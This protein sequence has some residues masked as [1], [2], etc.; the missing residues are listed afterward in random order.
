MC[1]Y[2]NKH[3][4]VLIVMCGFSAASIGICINSV[5]VFYTPVSI[6]L[7]VL[8]GSFIMH[9]TLSSIV[10]ALA[11]IFIL[12]VLNEKNLKKHLFLGVVASSASTYLMAYSNQMW[13]FH[14]LGVIRGI[15][16]SLFSIVVLTYIIN[17]W[18][19]DKKGL[20][21]SIVLSFGGIAGAIFSPLF[22]K[23]IMNYG[24]EN[25]YKLMAISIFLLC[26]PALSQSISLKPKT[27][28][29]YPYGFKEEIHQNEKSEPSK[30]YFDLKHISF[31]CI[32]IF[33]LLLTSVIGMT[34]HLPSY[35]LTIGANT[36]IGA[37]MVS[38]GMFG[39]IISKLT[40]GLL[41]DAIGAFKSALIMIVINTIAVFVLMTS[42][43]ETLLLLGSFLFG[44]IYSVSAVGI[45]LI[46]MDLFGQQ[47][48]SNVYPIISFASNFGNALSISLIGYLFDFTGSYFGTF[49]VIMIVN[50]INIILLTVAM[51]NRRDIEH[52]I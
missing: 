43:S 3:W 41:S 36:T 34:Q 6:S 35:A 50:I 40:I 23:V 38:F 51:K 47:N 7:N 30:T 26:L 24:W 12:K 49:I 2:H 48:Y 25:G 52:T 29:L 16:T 33:S 21:I 20:A 8:R 44:F 14:V 17:Q 31:Y 28:G 32:C 11:S 39:N 4:K 18:F 13:Q 10:S 42:S 15:G 27:L 5:G 45:S 1:D 37:L 9:I 19:Y 46:T 22:T